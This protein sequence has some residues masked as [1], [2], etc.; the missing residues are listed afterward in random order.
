[1]E[2]GGA[3][4]NPAAAYTRAMIAD[5]QP[6]ESAGIRID[7]WLWF[8]RLFKTRSQ[9]TDAVAGGLVHVN[10]ERVKPSRVVHVEDLLQITKDETRME[11]IVRGMPVRR[12]PSPEARMH[13]TETEQS[14]AAREQQRERNRMAAPAPDGR[15]D[16]HARRVLRD[17]RRG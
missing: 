8:A 6:D 14:I 13:Y 17:L 10:G 12:G 7:K 5:V 4:R 11:V 16:K 9:A 2:S 3:H 15:P 1:M